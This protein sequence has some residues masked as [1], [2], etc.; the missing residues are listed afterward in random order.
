MAILDE[1]VKTLPNSSGWI[2]FD[3][4][5]V[6]LGLMESNRQEWYGDVD[7]ADGVPQKQ[8]QD[9][10]DRLAVVNGLCRNL[11]DTHQ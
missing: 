10:L 9:Y 5:D 3:G 6:V 4:V 1:A 7:L 8:H 2:K 11:S